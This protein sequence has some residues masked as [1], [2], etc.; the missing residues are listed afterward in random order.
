MTQKGRNKK[1]KIN[2]KKDNKK[3]PPQSLSAFKLEYCD[4]LIMNN[5]SED[6]RRVKNNDLDKFINWCNEYGLIQAADITY[7]IL[8]RYRHHLYHYRKK[9]GNALSILGQTHILVSIRTFFKWLTKKRYLFYNPASELELPKKEKRLPETILTIQ[10]VEQVINQPDI[11]DPL[12]IRDRAI[13]ETFYSTGIRRQEM[14]RLNLYHLERDKG[15]LMIRLGKGK[16]DRVVPIGER[17]IAWIEKYLINVRPRLKM[18]P[19][20]GVLFLTNKG[21]LFSVNRLSDL[22]HDYVQAADIGKSGSCH[23]FRHAMATHMLENGA[24]VRIIQAILGHASLETTEIYTHVSITHLQ[25]VHK[26]T[27]PAKLE[28]KNKKDKEKVEE[29]NNLLALLQQEA[30]E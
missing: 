9:D 27:H 2:N 1:Q 18:Q 5:Y 24:D 8:E 23:L 3:Y 29:K 11:N 20:E 7:A 19:D 13:L 16:K 22:V 21:D 15:T 6:S 4:W 17:A 10:E 30:D 26:Q 25:A 28:K 12:G 14:T